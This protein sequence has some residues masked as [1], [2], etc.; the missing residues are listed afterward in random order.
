[1]LPRWASETVER[2][3]PQTRTVRGSDIQDWTNP[4]TAEV[5]GCSMQP[6]GTD[7]SQD[8]RIQGIRD[9]YTCY[10][11]PGTDIREGDRIRFD[12]KIYTINGIPREWKSPTGRVSHIQ[13]ELERWGG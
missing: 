3:R 7:L 12:G 8:G 1:M 6:S 9:G 13:L 5:T 4:E 2:L 10:M 11:P